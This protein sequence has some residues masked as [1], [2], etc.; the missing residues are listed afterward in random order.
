MSQV[1]YRFQ[2]FMQNLLLRR[3]HRFQVL[4][5]TDVEQC[6]TGSKLVVR[7]SLIRYLKATTDLRVVDTIPSIWD[8]AYTELAN[9][10]QPA[11]V[12]SKKDFAIPDGG[13]IDKKLCFFCQSFLLL[14]LNT[15]NS[16]MLLDDVEFE[17]PKMK[18]WTLLE[19]P[20]DDLSI[21]LIA[22]ASEL[23]K[24]PAA[25]PAGAALP[26]LTNG[27]V[28]VAVET[29]K[30]VLAGSPSDTAK[31]LCKLFVLHAVLLKDFAPSARAAPLPATLPDI[32]QLAE[33]AAFMA[34][35]WPAMSTVVSNAAAAD[36][37]GEAG[38]CDLWDG[39]FLIRL[40]IAARASSDLGLS[41][42]TKAEA[43]AAFTAAGLAGGVA[44]IFAATP[45]DQVAAC[46]AVVAALEAEATAASTFVSDNC[47]IPAHPSQF[48]D[49]TAPEAV[50]LYGG[51]SLK[52]AAEPQPT[53][54]AKA[55]DTKKA[56]T[57]KAAEEQEEE[58]VADNWDD[59][60]DGDVA[61][62]WDADSDDDK[63]DAAAAAAAPAAAAAAATASDGAD[64]AA[65]DAEGA[66]LP[67]EDGSAIALTAPTQAWTSI[68]PLD[69]EGDAYNTHVVM[70]HMTTDGDQ[71]RALTA[72]KAFVG[73][74]RKRL[75]GRLSERE[76]EESFAHMIK[77]LDESEQMHCA[78]DLRDFHKK[79]RFGG[80]LEKIIVR[81]WQ[82]KMKP[83]RGE[84]S[85]LVAIRDFAKSLVDRVIQT[86][87]I[88]ET[89]ESAA[90]AKTSVKSA[91]MSSRESIKK[92]VLLS[93]KRKGD[94]EEVLVKV[95]TDTKRGRYADAWLKLDD[96][97]L[98]R[99]VKDKVQFNLTNKAIANLKART[100]DQSKGAGGKGKKGGKKGGKGKGK[101]GEP[102]V[103]EMTDLVNKYDEGMKAISEHNIIVVARVARLGVT[104]TWW[105]EQYAKSDVQKAYAGDDADIDAALADALDNEKWASGTV[106]AEIF[107]TKTVA[108]E[109]NKFDADLALTLATYLAR[110][111]FPVEAKLILAEST[112]DDAAR[113]A[114]AAAPAPI[115]RKGQTL[116]DFQMANMGPVLLRPKG[117]PDNRVKRFQPDKWQKDLLDAVDET[118]KWRRKCAELVKARRG[119]T[120]RAAS[121]L[122]KEKDGLQSK[123]IL[124]S[125]PTSSGKTFISFYAMEQILR[126]PVLGEGIVVFVSP[127][128]ALVNQ[129]EADLYA[130]FDK[131]FTKKSKARSMHGVFLK[132]YRHNVADCQVLVTVPECLEIIML[133]PLYSKLSSRIRWVIFDEVHCISKAGGAVWERM[134]IATQANFIALS[135]TIGNPEDFRTWLEKV[136]KAKGHELLLVKVDDRINDLSINI[137]D[138]FT[139]E[140]AILRESD[141][142]V[143]INPLGVLT[144][145]LIKS[146]GCVPNQTKLLPEHCWQIIHAAKDLTADNDDPEV[147]RMMGSLDLQAKIEAKAVSMLES[148]SL[149]KEIKLLVTH[150]VLKHESVAV[151]LIR[152]VGG[153]A[154]GIMAD[155]DASCEKGTMEYLENNLLD[156]L[157]ALDAAGLGSEDDNSLKRLP[158]I[159]FHLSVR[160]CTRLVQ[161]LSESLADLQHAAQ[162]RS[163]CKIILPEYKSAKCEQQQLVGV[164]SDIV[165]RIR[166]TEVDEASVSDAA[167]RKAVEMSKQSQEVTAMEM[168]EFLR[169]DQETN[170]TKPSL[171]A[172]STKALFDKIVNAKV[173][174]YASVISKCKQEN[175]RREKDYEDELKGDPAGEEYHAPPQHVDFDA[176]LPEFI[177]KNFS[178][179]PAGK[180]VTVDDLKEYLGRWYD[181]KD[182][183]TKALQRGIGLHFPELPRK[184]KNAVERLFRLKKLRVVIATST[185]AL[186]INMP[187]K[188]A[189]IA[190]DEPHLN[191]LEY[192]QM[193]GRAGRR[194]FD[195]RGN[196]VFIGTPS[197]KIARLLSSN[198]ADL[199][200][201]VPLTPGL[202][203]RLYL[204]YRLGHS[205]EDKDH[206]VAMAQRLTQIPFFSMGGQSSVQVDQLLFCLDFLMHKNMKMIGPNKLQTDITPSGACMLVSHL[207]FL[208]PYNFVII[209]LLQ[210]GVFDDLVQQFVISPDANELDKEKIT[211]KRN[212]ALLELFAYLLYPKVLPQNMRGAKSSETSDVRLP[213]LP[214]HIKSEITSYN[215]FVL[216]RFSLYMRRYAS[217]RAETLGPADVLPGAKEELK[218]FFT[219]AAPVEAAADTALGMLQKT[220][221][222][223]KARTPFLALSGH[224]DKFSSL[225]DLLGS[226][227]PGMYLDRALVPMLPEI[228]RPCNSFLLDFY[229]TGE[230]LPLSQKNGLRDY[231]LFD[232][233]NKVS[234][235]I[236]VMKDATE[237]RLGDDSTTAVRLDTMEAF[238]KLE[239]SFTKIFKDEFAF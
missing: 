129:V 226:L 85:T 70:R 55:T 225:N 100:A 199:V 35:V 142:I 96:L 167:T 185:L 76:L 152:R 143:P 59:D 119:L 181:P 22:D 57:K 200:G 153:K 21:K 84:Q 205:K 71:L 64:A 67:V 48:L 166:A 52:A 43:E 33:Y 196:V 138:P 41:A 171:I 107:K 154:T 63:E 23:C 60:S 3:A 20:R 118:G 93:T 117:A 217:V 120:M 24:A 49:A 50:A 206:V 90:D 224:K 29:V 211:E 9:V 222:A 228:D 212:R 145:E 68:Q 180:P 91:V 2:Q 8:P 104:F 103:D 1:F 78:N 108:M 151:E 16:A 189:V 127:T 184:Y 74:L 179:L 123:S 40:T 207:Y 161:R 66:A 132:E 98:D 204:R 25:A 53:A 237:R 170:W 134:L 214:G 223:V 15:N 126:E 173:K 112:A 221:M 137:Y 148:A 86:E 77:E 135:A 139:S 202:A 229:S 147:Q 122:V 174:Y 38:L 215:D 94:L 195:N 169:V 5:F 183:K 236:R 95:A 45:K 233:L 234:H 99:C 73:K 101:G 163:F 7:Q 27:R 140:G 157:N 182:F 110:V 197:R 124:V 239:E 141:R 65:A 58:D 34:S 12:I 30:T 32:P 168:R 102:E 109:K 10:Q 201:N 28:S 31:E 218:C 105:L 114:L 187:C 227:R 56:D 230:R 159:V 106:V 178:F 128:K 47:A 92:T 160:G 198:V 54:V 11:F 177:D 238:D 44:K 17:G 203:L 6:W 231:L 136:E 130:R 232:N 194:T 75:R 220:A 176:L 188:T 216:E 144:V 116:Y 42:A 88:V 172:P 150:L 155:Q 131:S 213:Q 62:D 80:G 14:S 13:E 39:R 82:G 79:N 83:Q 210:R 81:K 37:Q 121:D 146:Q 164:E 19:R 219:A 208:E 235:A 51:K 115:D 69:D 46:A 193:I 113:E 36:I 149:E 125:A 156:C 158:A 61:D 191:A 133:D 209:S 4:F 111:G 87:V 162:A 190:G 89:D 186:G 72:L 175:E 165:Y 192:H 26:A 97:L 18:A